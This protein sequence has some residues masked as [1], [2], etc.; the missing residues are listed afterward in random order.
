[1]LGHVLSD[2]AKSEQVWVDDLCRACAEA[3]PLLAQ[4]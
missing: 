4:G 3:L 1:V 2:F